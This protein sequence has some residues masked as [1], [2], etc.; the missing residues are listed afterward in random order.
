LIKIIDRFTKS[1]YSFLVNSQE[2]A[3]GIAMKIDDP[4]LERL[5]ATFSSTLDPNLL[6]EEEDEDFVD[7]INLPPHHHHT[8][9]HN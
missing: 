6:I 7:D 8:H 4:D 2:L 3:K 1:G 5:R 9:H